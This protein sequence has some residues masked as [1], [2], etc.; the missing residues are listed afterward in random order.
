M[1]AMGLRNGAEFLTILEGYRDRVR[2][3]LWGHIHQEFAQRWN[4]IEML[5]TPST[6]IQFKPRADRYTVDAL[7][8]GYR[9]L[10]LRPN[11]DFVTQVVRVG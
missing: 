7:A 5:G 3:V 2:A 11:G 10:E 1:D 6:C 9:W 8:P 4:G